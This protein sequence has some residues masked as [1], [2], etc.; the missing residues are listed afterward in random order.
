MNL[1][2]ENEV[3]QRVSS[4][5][6]LPSV[7]DILVLFIKVLLANVSIRNSSFSYFYASFDFLYKS[8]IN[9]FKL[10]KYFNNLLISIQK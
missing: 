4:G 1:I 10:C 2:P 7:G 5:A 8:I 3:K 6:G 9:F